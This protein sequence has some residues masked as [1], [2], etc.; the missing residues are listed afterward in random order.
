M[1]AAA[2]SGRAHLPRLG[3]RVQGRKAR[4]PGWESVQEGAAAE[5]GVLAQTSVEGGAHGARSTSL[6]PWRTHSWESG[7]HGGHSSAA[8][9]MTIG[10]QEVSK[11]GRVAQKPRP[12]ETSAH[13]EEP[14]VYLPPLTTHTH[15]H[16]LPQYLLDGVSRAGVECGLEVSGSWDKK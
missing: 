2:A 6:A 9:E 5:A 8:L 14:P 12:D 1:W 15:S 10:D 7:G 3:P 4:D 13:L 11:P 16:T